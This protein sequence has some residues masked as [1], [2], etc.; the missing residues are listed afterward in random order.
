MVTETVNQ[1]S[2]NET[3]TKV[4]WGPCLLLEGEPLPDGIAT[5]YYERLPGAFDTTREAMEAAE[6][7]ARKRPD[8]I[9]Y[10][11]HQFS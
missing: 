10:T 2:K 9:G 11:A 4:Q 3:A 1:A 5:S 8:A 6:Q 7:E